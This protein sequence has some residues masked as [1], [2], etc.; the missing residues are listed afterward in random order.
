MRGTALASRLESKTA[1]IFARHE[2]LGVLGTTADF[3]SPPSLF[4][5][6]RG[7]AHP[8]AS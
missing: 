5:A 8:A 7:A 3:N 2:E 6:G 1:K 4:R